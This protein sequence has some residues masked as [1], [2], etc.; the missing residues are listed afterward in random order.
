MRFFLCAYAIK[1][2]HVRYAYGNYHHERESIMEYIIH[3]QEVQDYEVSVEADSPK[4]ALRTILEQWDNDGRCPFD[5]CEE[6]FVINARVEKF[7]P[8]DDDTGDCETV[9]SI[10]SVEG[11]PYDIIRKLAEQE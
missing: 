7:V 6:P 3:Y 8:Y 9:M 2:K 1:S 4:E 11:Y 5:A 10:E